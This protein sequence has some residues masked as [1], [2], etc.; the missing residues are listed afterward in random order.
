MPFAEP[1]SFGNINLPQQFWGRG[2]RFTSPEGALADASA[3]SA[4]IHIA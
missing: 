4:F 2:A 1:R 3:E